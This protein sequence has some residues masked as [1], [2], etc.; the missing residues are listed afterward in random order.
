M[1]YKVYLRV[2][3]VI[4]LDFSFL[5]VVVLLVAHLEICSLNIMVS[6]KTDSFIIVCHSYKINMLE[7]IVISLYIILSSKRV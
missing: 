7:A 4:R 6:F 2:L 3:L 1:S 5:K